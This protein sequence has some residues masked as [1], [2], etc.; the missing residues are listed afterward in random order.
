MSVVTCKVDSNSTKALL[1]HCKETDW[2]PDLG[3]VRKL[4][5]AGADVQ[6][7]DPSL[8]LSILTLLTFENNVEAA[9][10]CLSTPL[11][12]NFKKCIGIWNRTYIHDACDYKVTVEVSQSLLRR[13]VQRLSG[14]EN[15]GDEADWSIRDKWGLSIVDTMAYRSRL[16]ILW[17]EVR[18][19]PYFQ[20]MTKTSKKRSSAQRPTK[21]IYIFQKDWDKMTKEHQNE[22]V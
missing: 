22:V 2:F 12:L 14:A 10:V 17:P 5:Q 15:D 21:R 6:Y 19:V 13:V 11:P 16:S 9:M 3:T 8:D 18:E 20:Q 4:V 1:T 7:V